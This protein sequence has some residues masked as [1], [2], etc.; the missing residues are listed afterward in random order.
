MSDSPTCLCLAGPNGSGKST[1]SGALRARYSIQFWIDP[2]EVARALAATEAN[3]QVTK[4]IA[5]QAFRAGRRFR[6]GYATDL[7]DFGFETDFSH[8]SNVAFLRALKELG[9]HVHLHFV[10]TE[11]PEINVTRVCNRVARGGHHVED[12]TV[13]ERYH[14][15]LGLLALSL[16][17][18][19]RV[20]LFDNSPAFG[21]APASTMIGR[22][23]ANFYNDEGGSHPEQLTLFPPLPTWS[24]I[25]AVFPYSRGWPMTQLARELDQRFGRDTQFLPHHGLKTRTQRAQFLSQFI[26]DAA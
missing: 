5:T 18:I 16:R 22:S 13:R 26:I 12:M 1:L 11:D 24:V 15:S 17:D 2:D 25:Y 8:G 4:E 9:Y 19:D 14:R 23:V 21:I 10:C 6:V 20:V 7:Q 3:N